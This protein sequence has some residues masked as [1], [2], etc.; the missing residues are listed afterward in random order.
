MI[1]CPL[2]NCTYATPDVDDALAASLLNLHN[3]VYINAN[4]SSSKPKPPKM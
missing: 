1:N 4:A 3:N 2:D